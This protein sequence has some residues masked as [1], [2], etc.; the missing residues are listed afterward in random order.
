MLAPIEKL[1][2]PGGNRIIQVTITRK[3]DVHDCSNCTQLLPFRKDEKEMSLEC[4]EKALIYLQGWEGVIACFGG[5]PCSHSRFEEVCRLWEK[6]VPDQRQRGLWTNNLLRHGA[7]ARQTFWPNGMFNLNVHGNEQAAAD[8]R[9]WLPGKEIWG[10][11]ERVR[12]GSML[13]AWQDHSLTEEQWVELR[14]K[15]PINQNWS[16]AVYEREGEPHLYFCEVAGALDG[17]RQPPENHG[18]KMEPGCA[19]WTM[20]KFQGQI[21]GCCD[22]GC[23]VPLQGLGHFDLERTYDVSSSLV[24]LTVDPIGGRTKVVVSDDLGGQTHEL[25]DYVGLRNQDAR[26]AGQDAVAR[27]PGRPKK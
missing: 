26:R 11:G 10:A 9:R 3:C 19:F 16:A 1:R 5:N 23:G 6:H 8:M 25:T 13:R 15:C 17:I 21:A 7:I 24:Q 14:E 2:K 20:E 12:H 18:V 27:L 22:R 4:I